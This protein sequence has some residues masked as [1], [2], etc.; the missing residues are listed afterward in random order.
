MEQ[1]IRALVVAPIS[2]DRAVVVGPVRGGAGVEMVGD[3]CRLVLLGRRLDLGLG[4]RVLCPEL[5]ET[6]EMVGLSDLLVPD[7]PALVGAVEPH[8]LAALDR[9]RAQA[10]VG[11]TVVVQVAGNAERREE[12]GVEEVGPRRDAAIADLEDVQGPG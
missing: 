7:G 3:L 4:V 5:A 11:T 6:V 9:L 2:R 8:H 10:A 1:K 12:V